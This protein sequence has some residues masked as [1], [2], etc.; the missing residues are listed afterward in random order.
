LT[1]SFAI[2]A[3]TVLASALAMAVPVA[4]AAAGEAKGAP[5]P[6]PASRRIGVSLLEAAGQPA[7]GDLPEIRARG[8][9]R[10]LVPYGLTTFYLHAGEVRGV[11]YDAMT[12]LERRL[13]EGKQ[14]TR[15]S[16]LRVVFIP[17][18]F[19][20][21]LPDLMSGKGDVAASLLTVTEERKAIVDFSRPYMKDV[22]SVVVSRTGSPPV[23]S[24]RDLAGRVL[25]VPGGSSTLSSLRELSAAMVAQGLEP[26]EVVE[27]P[28]VNWEDVLQMVGS[29]MLDHTVTDD[30]L[31]NL[32]ARALPSLRV[33]AGARIREGA[34]LAWAVRK[35]SPKL[36]A[37]LDDL[38][39][40]RADRKHSGVAESIRR[41]LGDP[42]RLRNALSPDATAK[43]MNLRP[44]FVEA[45]DRYGLDWLFLAAQAYQES[46]LD[47]DARNPSGAV[48]LFQVKPETGAWLGFPDVTGAREN[49]MAGA[50]YMAL[51]R[52]KYFDDESIE[53]ADRLHF[54]LA[55]Y[56]A[57]PGRVSA[58]RKKART[59][60]LDPD[61]WFDHVEV[62]ALREIGQET[63]RY[64]ANVVRYYVAYRLAAELAERK[65]RAKGGAAGP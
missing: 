59:A 10:V 29:G 40:H 36:R 37:A 24:T 56:N 46:R 16:R 47:P 38:A 58:L 30:R 51:L 41:Y 27:V 33:D 1:C 35:E 11:E 57:G 63:P 39:T 42:K 48:G 62:V 55:A 17:T 21:L 23:N 65:A 13:N 25:H 15:K 26:V 34:D 44:F 7:F 50:A 61:R 9:L 54:S 22:A 31:A 18:P 5:A 19:D 3:W 12:E 14:A 2:R 6:P 28:G 45:G 53:M 32:W 52:S 20:R 60:G 4:G 64:V 43:K 8:S 49:A